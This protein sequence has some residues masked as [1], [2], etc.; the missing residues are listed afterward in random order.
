MKTKDKRL[1]LYEEAMLLALRD[2]KGTVMTSFPDQVVAGAVLAELLLDGRISVEDNKKQLVDVLHDGQL[3]DPLMDECLEK[4]ASSKRRASVRTWVSRLAGIKH[5]RHR[6]AKQLCERGI[7]R[8]DEDKILLVFKRKIYPE[9]NSRPER[10]IINRLREAIFTDRRQLDP[11]TVVLISLAD[12]AGLL[13]QNFGRKEIKTRKKR[14]EQ[15]ASGDLL[16]RTT[17]DVIAACQTALIVAAVMPAIV[18]TTVH[19]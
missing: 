11:R 16:G 10:R 8:A 3:G 19:N 14:I 5:L 18:S 6:V 4:I 7:L 2:E 15:I 13:A 17:R 1:F 9:I 12:G